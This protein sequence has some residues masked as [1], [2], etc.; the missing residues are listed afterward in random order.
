[1]VLGMARKYWTCRKCS[2]RNE[3]AA[4]KGRKCSDCGEETRPK[5]R[6]PAHAVTLRDDSYGDYAVLSVLIHGGKP[7]ACAVCGKPKPDT[8]GAKRHHRDHDH[9]TGKAR[10]LA[11]FRCNTILLRGITLEEARAIVAYHERVEAFYALDQ[12]R[13]A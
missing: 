13:L 2:F 3:H 6:V 5:K 1:M 9:T 8:E 11:C 7:H 12:V 4:H 10:G